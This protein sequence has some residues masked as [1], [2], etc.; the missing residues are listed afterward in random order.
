MSPAPTKLL[1]IICTHNPREA[2][3]RETLEAL[4]RQTVPGT[5]WDLLVIDNCSRTPLADWLDLAW[6]S[7]ARIV[8]E[9][10]LGTAYARLHALQFGGE[11]PMQWGGAAS[12]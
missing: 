7:H 3:L 10:R 8:R 11:T 6:H 4:R 2:G 9:E 12:G 1:V 5:E